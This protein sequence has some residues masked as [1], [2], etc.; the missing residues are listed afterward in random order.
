MR[1]GGI[2]QLGKADSSRLKP[3]RNDKGEI[4]W[5]VTYAESQ[6]WR[7]CATQKLS[8][9]RAPAPH[10]K[11]LSSPEGRP[12]QSSLSRVVTVLLSSPQG[13]AELRSAWADETSAPTRTSHG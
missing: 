5:L 3:V 6:R 13:A 10:L 7:R 12:A 9:A 1:K 8:R 2:L 11:K 4:E